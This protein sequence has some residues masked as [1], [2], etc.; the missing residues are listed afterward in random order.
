MAKS[1]KNKRQMPRVSC[2][3]VAVRYKRKPG[4]L[5]RIFGEDEVV[6]KLLPANDISGNGIRIETDEQLSPGTHLKLGIKLG[7]DTPTLPVEGRVVWQSVSNGTHDYQV[8]IEYVDISA[9]K[10]NQ[11]N[12]AVRFLMQSKNAFSGPIT[13]HDFPEWEKLATYTESERKKWIKEVEGAL[14]EGSGVVVNRET[15]GATHLLN[16]MTQRKFQDLPI[17]YS[18][19]VHTDNDKAK[20]FELRDKVEFKGRIKEMSLGAAKPGESTQVRVPGK[21]R[22]PAAGYVVTSL[23]KAIID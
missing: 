6:S 11:I 17:F 21:G 2:P 15:R 10:Q 8:S 13:I 14:L 20:G 16:L 1:K 3:G 7:E 9:Q 18:F 12:S 5:K 23:R 4:F 22:V 19:S